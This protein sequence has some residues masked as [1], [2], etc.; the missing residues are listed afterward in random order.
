VERMGMVQ[1]NKDDRPV[2]EMSI[3]KARIVGE[4]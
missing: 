3:I 4:E 1:T 2:E